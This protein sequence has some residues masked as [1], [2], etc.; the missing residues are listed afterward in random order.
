[1]NINQKIGGIMVLYQ[2][3]WVVTNNAI[4][5]LSPQVDLL[6]IVD[7]TPNTDNTSFIENKTNIHYIPLKEN[8]GIAAAQNIGIKILLNNDFD[9]VLF[10][11][12]DS[13]APLNIVQQLFEVQTN[14]QNSNLNVGAIGPLPIQRSTST[15][16]IKKACIRKK[17]NIQEFEVLEM[18]NIISSFS[19][20]KL[21]LFNTVGFFDENL[22][23]DGVD[24]EW[25]WR[26][27]FYHNLSSFLIP[28]ITIS[29]MFGEDV[30]NRFKFHIST[31]FRIYYQ[32]R[33]YLKLVRLKHTPTWWKINN[34][35]KYIVKLFYYPIFLKPHIKYLKNILLG[36]KHG[37]QNI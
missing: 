34:G 35:I 17:L 21:S 24:S 30:N 25:C 28:N 33:N 8:K 18:D 4:N 1:M 31:P 7:N 20:I 37:I 19:L 14:L 27:K 6:C 2:P 10:S 12:Q 26:A 9:F 15:P 32:Y 29:H 5:S 3:D 11:D 22:F 16:I 36:I 23:I 13:I